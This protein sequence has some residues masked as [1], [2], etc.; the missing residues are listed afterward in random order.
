MGNKDGTVADALR[1]QAAAAG[2]EAARARQQASSRGACG[3]DVFMRGQAAVEAMSYAA[4]FLLVFVGAATLFLQMQS[5][6]LTR[7][8]YAYAQQVAYGF[9]DSIHIAALAGDGYFQTVRVPA[10]ML[11]RSFNITISRPSLRLG[12]QAYEETGIVYVD[13]EAS[14]GR[15]SSVSAPTITTSYNYW[16]SYFIGNDSRDFIVISS[17]AGQL[18]MTNRN[19]TIWITHA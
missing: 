12:S 19:G 10:D 3:A 9:A 1:W 7:A 8:E 5:Q 17:G 15:H 4:F 11:G 13:W 18:N 6:D 16:P 14:N 2:S